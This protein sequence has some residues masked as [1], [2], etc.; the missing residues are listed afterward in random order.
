MK[1]RPCPCAKLDF[2]VIWI[3]ERARGSRR[4]RLREISKPLH[5]SQLI[6]VAFGRPSI[7]L[8][9]VQSQRRRRLT[10]ENRRTRLNPR[11]VAENTL[12]TCAEAVHVVPAA[13]GY[14]LVANLECPARSLGARSECILCHNP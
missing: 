4:R 3:S 9:R 12:R 8:R 6:L 1:I 13:A 7:P 5:P 11:I 2:F 10:A 14:V